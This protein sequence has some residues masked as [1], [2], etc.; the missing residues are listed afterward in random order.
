MNLLLCWTICYFLIKV[1]SQNIEPERIYFEDELPNFKKSYSN[2]LTRLKS[3]SSNP[4][5]IRNDVSNFKEPDYNINVNASQVSVIQNQ[6]N[7]KQNTSDRIIFID[8][9]YEDISKDDL[10]KQLD[11]DYLNASSVKN[12][13]TDANEKVI[14]KNVSRFEFIPRISQTFNNFQQ[15]PGIMY[16]DK[17]NTGAFHDSVNRSKNVFP[18][19]NQVNYNKMY[20]P[21][22]T[23]NTSTMHSKLLDL[24]VFDST[25]NSNNTD[26]ISNPFVLDLTVFNSPVSSNDS[27]IFSNPLDLDLSV[28]DST[29]TVNN[30]AEYLNHLELDLSVY[31]ETKHLDLSVF[32]STITT[33]NSTSENI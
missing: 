26:R 6:N 14:G 19:M 33:S 21:K 18:I 25:V 22:N 12:T 31:N 7:N 28:F 32:D 23:Y 17:L 30:T 29:A 5:N 13:D 9:F 24:S 27:V 16:P 1:H 10:K 3:T 4:V 2:I 11:Y 15:K 20:D 8:D